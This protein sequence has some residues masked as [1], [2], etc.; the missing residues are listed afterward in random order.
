MALVA[1]AGAACCCA[2]RRAQST[3]LA[4]PRSH[5]ALALAG[6][7]HGGDGPR[8]QCR[9]PASSARRASTSRSEQSATQVSV[10]ADSRSGSR[11]FG[12][13]PRVAFGA[14]QEPRPRA[15]N[16]SCRGH[17]SPPPHGI[18]RGSAEGCPES[19]RKDTKHERHATDNPRTRL[20]TVGLLSFSGISRTASKDRVLVQRVTDSVR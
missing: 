20:S 16:Q 6:A 3:D 12:V 7:A 4:R 2:L 14:Q 9:R 19:G 15:G 13:K 18:K 5:A 10:T 1:A 17:H 11:S 8:P